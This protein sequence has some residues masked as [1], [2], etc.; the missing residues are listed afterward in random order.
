MWCWI[1]ILWRNKQFP[2]DLALSSNGQIK[3]VLSV[4]VDMCLYLAAWSTLLSTHD[5][6]KDW[7]PTAQK[8]G[9]YITP[10]WRDFSILTTRLQPTVTLNICPPGINDHRQFRVFIQGRDTLDLAKVW[11]LYQ[12][13]RARQDK[14]NFLDGK[15]RFCPLS[16]WVQK[17]RR[18]LLSS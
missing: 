2:G 18:S 3:I 6:F 13:L 7:K 4:F 5:I 9:L 14:G 12:W 1:L 10:A 17:Y 16:W 8:W 15:M 11:A